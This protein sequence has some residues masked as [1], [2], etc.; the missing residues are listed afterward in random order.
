MQSLTLRSFPRTVGLTLVLLPFSLLLLIFSPAA[1]D[2]AFFGG[3]LSFAL[4]SASLGIGLGFDV[5]C[6]TIAMFR[7]WVGGKDIDQWGQRN[8]LSHT[9]LT[10]S[11]IVGVAWLNRNGTEPIALAGV[12]LSLLVVGIGF[13]RASRGLSAAAG[14][15]KW[16]TFAAVHF[17]IAYKFGFIKPI[18]LA[19]TLLLAK[20]LVLEVF[21]PLFSD[22]EGDPGKEPQAW[23]NVWAVSLDCPLSSVA[24]S[25]FVEGWTWWLILASSPIKGIAVAA[26]ALAGV[27]LALWAQHGL[28]TVTKRGKAWVVAANVV[29][30]YGEWL[31]LGF[32]MWRISLNSGFGLMLTNGQIAEISFVASSLLFAVSLPFYLPPQLR[33]AAKKIASNGARADKGD[34]APSDPISTPISIL[35]TPRTETET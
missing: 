17:F 20:L 26:M 22:E 35:K 14:L 10:F 31:V 16:G 5:F 3:T 29:P 27:V 13:I 6:A 28:T 34:N 25:G 18:A 32:F 19:G 4:L 7:H 9:L 2:S 8:T 1:E 12:C 30:R 11:G 33:L 21:V 15:K 23:R 24:K